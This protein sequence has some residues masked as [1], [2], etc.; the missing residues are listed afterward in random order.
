MF[1]VVIAF[2]QISPYNAIHDIFYGQ[3]IGLTHFQRFFNSI[4]F[5][6][7]LTNTLVISGL[8]LL[9]AFPA[10]IVLAL[11]LNEVR[12]SGFKR[13]VQTISYMPHFLSMVVVTG[14]VTNLLSTSVG[15]VNGLLKALG[16]Q[17]ISFLTHPD[18]FRQIL[19]SAHVWQTVGW[20]T[21]LYLA[22]MA[23]IPQEHYEAASIDGANRFQQII[24]I[25]L[26]SIAFVIVI[27]FIFAVGNLLNAGF[28]QI[29][30]LYSPAVYSVAD[31]IDTYVYRQGLI[32][33]D[34]SYAA[35]VSLFKSVLAMVLLLAANK[36]AQ[37]LGEPGL[38]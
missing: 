7:V 13:V 23:N 26:P 27:L 22:A 1:G 36:L 17:P 20:G 4:Y 37:K 31:I 11:L 38:W 15:P 32:S 25:T 19:V 21:I 3:W 6:N 35:A 14:L 8:K 33:L 29:L 5:W 2:K 10:S 9:F 28:E 16:E 30:L 18:F 34:Y 24:Y 12:H